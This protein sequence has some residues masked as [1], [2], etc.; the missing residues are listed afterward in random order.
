MSRLE[1]G[2]TAAAKSPNSLTGAV[3]PKR[4]NV[5]RNLKPGLNSRLS[6]MNLPASQHVGTKKR[7]ASGRELGWHACGK[8]LGEWCIR[9]RQ[10]HAQTAHPGQAGLKV[11]VF[12]FEFPL[13]DRSDRTAFANQGTKS[14]C[15]ASGDPIL[16]QAGQK[17]Q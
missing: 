10:A 17:S 14:S 15:L 5:R 7:V 3:L 4:T 12:H 2:R 9:K 13:L 1:P 16:L 8:A 11:C 6:T